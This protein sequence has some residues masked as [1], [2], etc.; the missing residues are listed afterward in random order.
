M[1]TWTY[2]L[3]GSWC[4]AHRA[5]AVTAA[6][7]AADMNQPHIYNNIHQAS[8]YMYSYIIYKLIYSMLL[9]CMIHIEG[10]RTASPNVIVITF[11]GMVKDGETWD[12]F[13]LKEMA[14]VVY[15]H[16]CLIHSMLDSFD[17]FWKMK[18]VHKFGLQSY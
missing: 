6:A 3:Y 9:W 2:I 5:T 7:A 11:Y 15:M 4:W 12:I 18:D 8:T 17:R 10:P 1:E 16:F 13:I 14:S